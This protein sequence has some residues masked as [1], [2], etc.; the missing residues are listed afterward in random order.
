MKFGSFGKLVIGATTE[1]ET[2]YTTTQALPRGSS[3]L[4]VTGDASQ[5][6]Q[7]FYAM[8]QL[9]LGERLSVSWGGRLDHD[10]LNDFVTWRTTAAYS[11]SES[12]TKLRASVGTG[13]KS[14]S[15][16]QR[17]SLY[18]SDQLQPEK[19]IGIDAGFDQDFFKKD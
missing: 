4:N 9:P 14:P 5:S 10:D 15:L 11:I 7:S 6:T 16:F 2:A 3:I 13:A 1:T 17:F 19:N 12:D 8:H 18:G